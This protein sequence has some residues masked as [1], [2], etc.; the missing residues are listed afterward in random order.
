MSKFINKIKCKLGFHKWEYV[1]AGDKP[2]FKSCAICG[3]HLTLL[4]CCY[5]RDEIRE[6]VR[7]P[8]CLKCKDLDFCVPKKTEKETMA[9]IASKEILDETN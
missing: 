4:A 9:F 1:V 6:S 3:R 7:N 8:L 2:L 5:R